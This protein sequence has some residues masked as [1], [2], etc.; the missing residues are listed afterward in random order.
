MLLEG[1]SEIILDLEMSQLKHY[2]HQ[3]FVIQ[4]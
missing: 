3:V 2:S 4:E 1:D